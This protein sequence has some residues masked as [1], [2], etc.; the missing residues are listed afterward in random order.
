MA[1]GGKP[2]PVT[3]S[4]TL[5]TRESHTVMPV[6]TRPSWHEY[7]LQIALAV[8]TRAACTR[9]QV[10]AVLV[11]D[12]RIVSSGYNG[13]PAGDT[14]CTDGGCPRGLLSY[15]ELPPGS[16]YAS[17]IALHAEINCLAYARDEARGGTLYI[18]RAPCDW[19]AKVIR[20]F[21][22][23]EVIYPTTELEVPDTDP[24][25]FIKQQVT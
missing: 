19:C 1:G 11:K 13:S 17:C 12:R 18:T 14:H 9:S 20:A 22:I 2:P 23:A 15:E 5:L 4:N 10:G 16:D 7:F 8:S 24:I 25:A 3:I 21:G 6:Q